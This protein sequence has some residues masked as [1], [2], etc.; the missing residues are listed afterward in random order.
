MKYKVGDRV[1]IRSFD[2]IKRN[3]YRSVHNEYFE[4]DECIYPNVTA[5]MT[6]LCGKDFMIQ[7]MGNLFYMLKNNA[8]GDRA[9]GWYWPE[10]IFEDKYFIRFQKLRK[11]YGR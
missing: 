10:W 2:W 9:E 6:K 7:S 1:R 4:N 11:L 5:N 3:A 8:E